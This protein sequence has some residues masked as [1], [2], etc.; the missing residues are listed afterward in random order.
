MARE[1]VEILWEQM[2][3]TDRRTQTENRA[4]ELMG[5]GEFAEAKEL[6]DSM[7]DTVFE[8]LQNEI[9]ALR[10]EENKE[11]RELE[12]SEEKYANAKRQDNVKSELKRVSFSNGRIR[13]GTKETCRKSGSITQCGLQGPPRVL[14]KT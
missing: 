7:D 14:C 4:F 10:A 12:G 5:E 1:K 11:H 2:D 13:A 9:E 6:L 3:D 8:S